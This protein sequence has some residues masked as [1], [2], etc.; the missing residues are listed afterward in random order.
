M[1]TENAPTLVLP[2]RTAN[3]LW[4][5]PI[6]SWLTVLIAKS[7]LEGLLATMLSLLLAGFTWIRF[8][9]DELFPPRREIVPPAMNSRAHANVV[10]SLFA[11]LGLANGS[12]AF[13]RQCGSNHT[14]NYCSQLF[15]IL[16]LKRRDS[17]TTHSMKGENPDE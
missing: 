13:G 15:L 8:Y 12:Y 7:C 9:R 10:L 4:C 5:R 17:S 3:W 16:K 14:G 11:I 6:Y 2:S 1:N